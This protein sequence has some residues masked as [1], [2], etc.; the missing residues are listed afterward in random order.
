MDAIGY[1]KITGELMIQEYK[2]SE[3]APL[4]ENQKLGFAELIASGGTVVGKGKGA[5]AKGFQIPAGVTVDVK[6]PKGGG[7]FETSK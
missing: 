7:R 1:D 6:R 2:S 4:S 5:F 3:T